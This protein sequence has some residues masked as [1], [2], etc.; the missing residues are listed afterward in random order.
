MD[1]IQKIKWCIIFFM[2][3]GLG[4]LISAQQQGKTI[5]GKVVDTNGEPIIGATILIKGTTRGT[6]T[7]MDG[8]YTL[9]NVPDDATLVFSFVGME[10]QEVQVG[11]RTK[12]D[13]VMQEEA[14][15]LE[16]VVVT[17]YTTQRK[18]DLTGA[19]A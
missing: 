14:L 17:G 10:S 3:L 12:I 11:N 18:A 5:T 8:N 9:S 13:V 16:E 1:K 2:L 19:V 7:D 15:G 6:V 4:Q